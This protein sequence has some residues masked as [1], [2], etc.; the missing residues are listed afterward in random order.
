MLQPAHSQAEHVGAGADQCALDQY[1]TEATQRLL[2]DPA[3]G[4]QEQV[5]RTALLGVGVQ[6]GAVAMLSNGI[7][8]KLLRACAVVVAWAGPRAPPLA[9]WP[10]TLTLTTSTITTTITTTTT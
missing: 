9:W 7:V 1:S 2:G 5:L 3:A 10:L 8:F 4:Q 6:I